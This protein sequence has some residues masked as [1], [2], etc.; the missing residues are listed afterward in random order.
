MKKLFGIL[1]SMI[2]LA[3]GIVQASPAAL[4]PGTDYQVLKTPGPVGVPAGKIEVID[5]FWYGCWHCQNF[6]PLISAWSKKQSADV[7]LK[8]VPA[9]AQQ[10]HQKLYYALAALGLA[11]QLAPKIFKAVLEEGNPLLTLDK[12]ADFV[13]KNGV[14]RQKF[15]AA[16][17]SF[18]VA[19]AIRRDSKLLDDY[20]I[21]ST[22]TLV[23]QGK[24]KT[25]PAM[26]KSLENTVQVLDVLVSKIRAG[27]V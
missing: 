8:H 27:K 21:T 12:Q 2:G 1:L 17:H 16:W 5:F 22:P 10:A 19:N 13:S 25:S 4:T 7:V 26:T 11:E 23:I 6:A 3:L 15:S 9:T 20:Q 24:Y 14:D 18:S